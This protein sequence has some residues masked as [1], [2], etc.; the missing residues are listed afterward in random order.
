MNQNLA[1]PSTGRQ[2]G[3]FLLSVL[4]GI[5]LAFLASTLIILATGGLSADSSGIKAAQGISTDTLKVLQ[6]I[7]TISLFLVPAILYS[8]F[9]FHD[10]PLVHLGFIPPA[11]SFF[12]LLAILTLLVSF[13]FDGWL[14][15]LNKGIPLPGWM[16][17]RQ[18]TADK[19]I[20]DF[21][22]AGSALGVL[23]NLFVIAL[24][25]AICEEACFRGALQPI[26]IRS[27][28]SP[29]AGILITAFIF[30]ACHLQFQGFLPRMALG[31]LLGAIYWYSGSLWVS[32]AAHFVTNAVQVLVVACYPKYA[33]EDPF[34][35]LIF[36]LGS[37]VLVIAL[38]VAMKRQSEA[39]FPPE[40]Y[41]K[42]F[43]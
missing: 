30:S 36:A 18:R 43:Q 39:K 40:P 32:I 9:T 7:F 6:S 33:A 10:R 12:F 29:W 23:V 17:D 38:L 8:K 34:V 37:L 1:I 11:K 25:P 15:Q 26:M 35:P 28:R 42:E 21:L 27:T 22:Q 14:G 41:A 2:L 3:L 5:V 24:L 13:P 16:I 19:Q 20:I 4:G 31:I